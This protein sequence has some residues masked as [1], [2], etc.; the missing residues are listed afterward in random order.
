MGALR[1]LTVSQQ[2]GLLF[3]VLFGLLTVISV[4]AFTRTLRDRSEGELA[5]HERFKRDLRAVW[6]GSVL[7]WISWAAVRAD[8]VPR[9]ARVRHADPHPARRPSQPPARVLRGAAASIRDRR[10]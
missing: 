10:R 4:I 8:L 9:A 5:L 2:V 1:N 7:F 6:I 3:V